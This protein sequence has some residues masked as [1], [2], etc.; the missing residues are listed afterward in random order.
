MDENAIR[1]LIQDVVRKEL[2]SG[3]FT[4]RK[5]TDL[6]TDSFQVVNRKFVTLN[7]TVANRPNSSV[8]VVGQHYFPTDTNIPM[9]Y[10]GTRWRNGVGSV[11]A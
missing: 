4:A 3:L 1:R 8:A 5:L 9:T 11:V 10:D 7:G 2:N 6:P